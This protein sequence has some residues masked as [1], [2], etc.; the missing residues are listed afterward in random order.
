MTTAEAP[1]RRP[2]AAARG[3]RSFRRWRRGR[4]FWG[5][6]FT[7]LSGLEYF[8]SGHITLGGIKVTFVP[9]EFLGWLIPLLL[10]LCGF[11]L[12]FMPGQRVF[13][14]ILAAAVAV[15]GLVGLNL[16]G[17]VV[18]MI[19]GMIGGSLGASWAPVGLPPAGPPPTPDPR[20]AAAED[21]TAEHDTV[22]SGAEPDDGSVWRGPGG[23]AAMALLVLTVAVGVTV[24]RGASPASAAPACGT[25]T[26]SAMASPSVPVP[27]ASG[28]P[29]GTPTASPTPATSLAPDGGVVKQVVDGVLG[30][31]GSLFGAG[32]PQPSATPTTA[33]PQ[34]SA[35]ASASPTVAATTAKPKPTATGK[36]TPKAGQAAGCPPARP[37]IAP[38]DQT[39]AAANPAEQL[40]ANLAQSQMSY[41]GVTD[42]PTATGTLRVLQ[43]SMDSS[44]S[45]PFE[46]RVPAAGGRTLVLRS[47]Q[48]T[49][50][51][52]VRFY[53]T[54]LDGKL[55]GL[56]VTF[57][58]D[59]PPPLPQ[60]LPVPLVLTDV[61][62][63]LALVHADTLTAPGLSIAYS[64]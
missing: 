63:Q 14:G 4:P 62:L 50:S 24:V 9:Q 58:P 3:W 49:V 61:T 37:L 38:A 20:Y 2:S 26:A 48:L 64:S 15:G 10:L 40:T 29:S 53:T 36:T 32:D 46:L 28:T 5:A 47:T 25:P 56:P 33:S 23:L 60:G 34:P 1:Y 27:S 17:F 54:R 19:L 44:T 6:F 41:D 39:R 7:I 18:G 42:L 57:T 52:N 45:T 8:F 59:S 31:L 11:L 43:F 55:L 30:V 51:G 12:L 35:T 16:G 21:D 22:E 13:Y